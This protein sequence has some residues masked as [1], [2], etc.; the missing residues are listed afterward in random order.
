MRYLALDLGDKRT[1]VA[2]G[3]TE[4]GLVFPVDVL[5]VPVHLASGGAL[6]EAIGRTVEEHL[7]PGPHPSRPTSPGQI[8]IGLPINMDGKEGPAARS[9]RAFADRVR[10]RTGRVVHLQDERLTSADADWSMS[11]SGLTRQQKK[12]R[13]DALAAAAILRDFLSALKREA[14]APPDETGAPDQ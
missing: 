6:L 1:G 14:A 2:T 7:G 4:T 3:D 9:A 13:R 12:D 8:V 5:E 10:Q 11:R